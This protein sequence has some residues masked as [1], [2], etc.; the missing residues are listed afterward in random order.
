MDEGKVKHMTNAIRKIVAIVENAERA[1]DRGQVMLTWIG[2]LGM[3]F[4]VGLSVFWGYAFWALAPGG[5]SATAL[6]LGAIAAAVSFVV[7]AIAYAFGD[8]VDQLAALRREAAPAFE[9]LNAVDADNA[10][11]NEATAAVVEAAGV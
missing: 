6:G 3:G 7:I 1:A 10:D 2:Y 4:A 5:A 9:H 11:M 8:M